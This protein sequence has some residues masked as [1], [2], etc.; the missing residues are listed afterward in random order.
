MFQT[1]YERCR[2]SLDLKHHY[3]FK[4][5]A[6]NYEQAVIFEDDVILCDNFQEQ[7]EKYMNELPQNYDMMF[8]G[9]GCNLH[10]EKRKLVPNQHIYLKCLNP[11]RW[12]GDGA[13]RC[14]DS[15]I[16]SNK[17][18]KVLCNYLAVQ[19]NIEKPI[20]WWLN[21][22][23]RDNQFKVY[24]AEPTIV[25]QGSQHGLFNSTLIHY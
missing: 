8:I 9:D 19:K 20:D 6:E 4:Q 3:A 7:L 12:G 23:A 15:Y 17:C 5:I 25:T 22:A 24:W 16:I 21:V 18:A 1:G 2:M 13:T 14:S 10:I 11:T